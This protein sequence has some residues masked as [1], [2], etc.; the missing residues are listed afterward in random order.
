MPK[1][2]ACRTVVVV[3]MG[4]FAGALGAADSKPAKSGAKP[5][6]IPAEARKILEE[7]GLKV[8]TGALSLPEEIEFGKS[9]RE[10]KSKKKALMAADR[11]VYATQREIDGIKDQIR[12][13]KLQYKNLNI[14]LTNVTNAVANNKIVGALNAT[15]AEVEQREEHGKEADDRL[16]EARKRGAELRDAFIQELAN[17]REQSEE[18]TKKWSS[19]A[20]EDAIKEA[21]DSINKALGSKFALQPASSFAGNLKQ[22]K[23]MEEAVKSEA[24]KLENENNSLWVNVTINDKQ[25]KRM[26]VDSGATA[27][28]LPD[29]MARD[30][31]IKTD[32]DGTPVIVT[33]A[34]GRKVPGT[35]IKLDSVKVGKFTVQDVDCCVLGS[36]ATDAP[37]LLGMSFLGQFKFEV[38]ADRAE[39]RLVKVDSGEPMPKDKARDKGKAKKKK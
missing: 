2:L 4:L 29:K 18:V 8:T 19:L 16:K 24:I 31:G 9:L 11:E 25:K 38:D 32:A 14:E 33:L 3:S 13:L 1:I 30:M 34:D 36:D 17:L 12:E 20:E 15:I 28:S 10:M 21:V 23:T 5:D 7:A 27:I 37:A 39:L 35:M 26:I 6:P 22:I